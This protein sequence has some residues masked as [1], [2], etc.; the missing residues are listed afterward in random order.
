MRRP[1]IFLTLL[2]TATTALAHTGVKDPNVIARM[3]GMK[4]MGQH[5]AILGDMA[6]G[7]TAFDAAAAQAALESL[8]NE[9]SR[10]PVLFETAA[11]DPKDEARAK[12]WTNWADFMSKNK[13]LSAVLT[14]A[15]ITGP[16]QL[17]QS[18]RD[19]GRACQACHEEY[20]IK[21]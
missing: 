10:V 12:I 21:K 8:L 9:T 1:A 15:D 16:D 17:R 5:T 6:K 20:R 2:A 4:S 11:R 7:K 18:L 14:K 13:N 19:I 3:Q